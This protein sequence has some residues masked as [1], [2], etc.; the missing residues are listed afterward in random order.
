MLLVACIGLVFNLIQ[1]KILHTGDGHY[2]LGG[3][4]HGHD[5]GCDHGHSHSHGHSHDHSHSHDHDHGEHV[6]LDSDHGDNEHHKKTTKDHDLEPSHAQK[7]HS[8]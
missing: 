8:I 2:H 7:N 3:E 4:N 6:H 5:H 1:I